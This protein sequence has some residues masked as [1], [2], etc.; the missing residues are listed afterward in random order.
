M[1]RLRQIFGSVALGV[2]CYSV[3]ASSEHPFVSRTFNISRQE[4]AVEIPSN[5]KSYESLLN[6]PLMLLGPFDGDHRPVIVIVPTEVPSKA[7]PPSALEKTT[8][9]LTAARIEGITE[10]GGA[11]LEEFPIQKIERNQTRFYQTGRRYSVGVEHGMPEVYE[12]H[13]F[14]AICG[15]KYFF[16]TAVLHSTQVSEWK[17]TSLSIMQTLR[18]TSG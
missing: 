11:L 6:T 8:P 13:S 14:H 17:G 16:L 3:S 18:C 5:W 10:R 15:G 1:L 9:A 4:F 2:F 7:V 12:Q